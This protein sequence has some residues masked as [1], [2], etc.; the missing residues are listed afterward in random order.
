M[1]HNFI[2]FKK[3][4]QLF[5][6]YKPMLSDIALTVRERMS[7]IFN[8]II[9]LF[10]ASPPQNLTTF[11]TGMFFWGKSSLQLVGAGKRTAKDFVGFLFFLKIKIGEFNFKQFFT[12]RARQLYKPHPSGVWSSLNK[13]SLIYPVFG[14]SLR[15]ISYYLRPSVA[16]F[17]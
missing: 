16:V 14:N 9:W 13:P 11:P 3:S 12:D 10:T 7:F 6:H 15:H 2:T 8:I 4:S 5:F 1:V 17:Q